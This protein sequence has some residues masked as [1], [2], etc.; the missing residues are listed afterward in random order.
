MNTPSLN[1]FTDFSNRSVLVTGAS[2]GIGAAIAKRFADAGARVFI[3]YR[4]DEAGATALEKEINDSGSKAHKVRAD[5]SKKS[6]VEAMFAEIEKEAGSIDV[7]INNAGNYPQ[8]SIVD[9][10]EEDWD[11]VMN[12]NLRSTYLC[13]R[14]FT[15]YVSKDTGGSIVNIASIEG[16]NPTPLH[17]HYCSAKSAVIMYSRVAANELAQYNIRCNVVLPGLIWAEGIEENWPEGV[18]G[19]KK[20]APLTRLGD[21]KDVANACLFLS[22]DA[23]NWITGAELRVDGGVMSNKI[24]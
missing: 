16:Q 12:A 10:E 13:T 24:F 11:S 17:S 2:G 18:E 23:A 6:D 20:A 19:W 3:H 8:H 14:A 15:K 9:M 21:A 7:L 4:S 1:E 5:V 22:S